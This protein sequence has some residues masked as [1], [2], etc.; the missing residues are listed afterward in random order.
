MGRVTGEVRP[1]GGPTRGRVEHLA[2]FPLPVPL[3]PGTPLPLHVFEPRYRQLVA[4]VEAA[5][6]IHQHFGVISTC[7]P[8]GM[9][10]GATVG[11][12]R[13]VGTTARVLEVRTLPDGRYDLTTIGSRR[14]RLLRLVEDDH[15]YLV[16]EV[17][18]IDEALREDEAVPP[19]LVSAVA[20]SFD[21]YITTVA[22]L[23]D[24][25]LDDLELPSSG[26]SLSWTVA[27]VALLSGDERHDLLATVSTVDRL[28][29]E[30]VMLRRE[31][32]LV[33]AT[34]T[35]PAT[36]GMLSIDHSES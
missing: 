22:A 7:S 2:L 24:L 13:A 36:D 11:D 14:F 32:A 30:L 9:S 29:R 10:P 17:E 19:E 26:E 35:L 16:G 21:R 8:A 31:T 3:F 1:D 12:L 5:A 33:K 28:T 15:P 25:T 23:Q 4:D 27:T 6:P 18:W 34:R 20:A